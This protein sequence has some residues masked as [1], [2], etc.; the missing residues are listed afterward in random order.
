MVFSEALRLKKVIVCS[1][2]KEYFQVTN[3]REQN[4]AEIADVEKAQL[5]HAIL[6][7]TL[8]SSGAEVINI[9]ELKGHPN[10]VFTRDTSLVTPRGFIRLRMG[11]KKRREEEHWMA[12]HLQTLNIPEVGVI[13]PPGTVEGG[14][15]ILAGNTAFV[16]HSVRSNFT[17]IRH[18]SQIL[19]TM[20]YEVRVFKVPLPHLHIGGMMSLIA[21]HTV[22]CCSGIFPPDYFKGF[23][24]V[25]LPSRT[26]I[27]GNVI[28]LGEGELIVEKQNKQGA[29]KLEK[30]GFKVHSLDLSEF[31]KGQGG[32]TCL[33]LP[34]VR[35]P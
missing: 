34:V 13:L 32:P 21:P 24:R 5:Q 26:S 30:E 17:G 22:L 12:E 18:L 6:Q 2:Q 9:P 10:S 16:G 19:K 29:E 35:E 7:Q 27:T 20:D 14:D 4:I 31:I 25:E 8:S 1:P 33:I 23:Q 11:L 28:C 3:L 15:V